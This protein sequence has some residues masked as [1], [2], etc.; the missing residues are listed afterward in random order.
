MPREKIVYSSNAELAHIWAQQTK[1]EGR[2]NNMFFEG[3]I[4]DAMI[5]DM[6]GSE[7]EYCGAVFPDECEKD[8]LTRMHDEVDLD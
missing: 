5:D 3:D 8:C 2:A 4:T 7:C 6:F 1:A